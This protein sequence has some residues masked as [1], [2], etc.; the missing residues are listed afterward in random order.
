MV[1]ILMSARGG[2]TASG[3]A[4]V[5]ALGWPLVE[6]HDPH[7]LH[8]IVSS[9][10]GRREHLIVS[11]PALTADAQAI[12]RGDLHGVRFFDLIDQRADTGAVVRTIR[13]QFGL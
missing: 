3:R 8:A 4:L 6:A 13:D 12:V 7:A 5:D 11:S 2:E 10:L 1:V 9:V